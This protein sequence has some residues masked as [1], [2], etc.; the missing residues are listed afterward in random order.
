MGNY[1]KEDLKKVMKANPKVTVTMK[2]DGRCGEAAK[3]GRSMRGSGGGGLVGSRVDLPGGVSVEVVQGDLTTFQADAIVNAANGRLDH[4]GGLAKAIVDAGGPDIQRECRDYVQRSG[5]LTAGQVYVSTPGQLPCKKVIHAVGPRWHGGQSNEE[6]DLYVAIFE[7]MQAAEKFGLSSVAFPA[8]SC[9]I[10]HYPLDKATKTIVSALKDF[11]ED[12]QHRCVKKVS[13]VDL[14]EN[15]VRE[16]SSSLDV[17]FGAD[18]TSSRRGQ[19]CSHK[20][21]AESQ[22]LESPTQLRTPEGI[23]LSLCKSEIAK[24]KVDVIVN[25]TNC[26]LQLERGYVS[27]ALLDRGGQTLQKECQQNAPNGI[28]S[29]EVVVTSGGQLKCQLVIHGACCRWDDGAGRSEQ[30]LRTFLAN[31][32]QEA[33]NNNTTLCVKKLFQFSRLHPQTSLRD[34]RFVVYQ[35]DD[36]VIQAFEEVLFKSDPSR[37]ETGRRLAGASPR[38]DEAAHSQPPQTRPRKPTGPATTELKTPEGITISLC[39]SEIAKEKV[40]GIV[41]STNRQLQLERGYVSKA[42][43]D[44]GGQTLQNECQ[45][46]APHGVKSGEVVVTSGGKLNCKFVIHGACCRWDGGT[47]GSEKVLRMLLA[48]CFHE[49]DNNKMTSV[50]IPP[51]GTGNLGFEAHFVAKVMREELFLFSQS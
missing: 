40:D 15:I 18:V 9:R 32:F 45:Q 12:K 3:G 48:N 25:S 51:I 16:L 29:G 5:V 4:C 20:K 21:G 38:H 6:N 19:D 2:T 26:Q 35:K 50:A 27:K 14:S 47:G 46:K 43:L 22:P 13:L 31:C 24:E 17:V 23:T 44:I 33:D 11:L 8:L 30:V 7:S 28:K 37:H 39:K 41:N 10:F 36:R 42:L 49:A 1:M 34:V